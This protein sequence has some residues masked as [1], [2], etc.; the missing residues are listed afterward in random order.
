MAS[1]IYIYNSYEEYKEYYKGKHEQLIFQI[2]IIDMYVDPVNKQLFVITNQDENA[3]KQIDFHRTIVHVR[4]QGWST[5][6]LGYS[7]SVMLVEHDKVFYN[8]KTGYID[9][10]PRFMKVS[11]YSQRADRVVGGNEKKTYNLLYD[12]KFYDWQQDRINLILGNSKESG[13]SRFCSRL[14]S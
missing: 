3:K 6:V 10:F 4:Q 12:L 14:K 2:P 1:S 5:D 11:K 9:F 8:G 13:W 7:G